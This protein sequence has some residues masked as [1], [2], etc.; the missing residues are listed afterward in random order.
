MNAILHRRKHKEE[1]RR[2]ILDAAREI[3]VR[4]GY[5]S[6][7]MRKLAKKIEYSPG[8]VYLHFKSKE[9]LFECLVEESFERLLKTLIGLGNGHERQ[10][11]VDEL[12]KGLWAYVNFGLHNPNDYRFA[13]MLR[14]PMKK[15]PYQVHRAFEALRNMVRRCVE[16]K[17]FRAV[18][19][20]TTSQALW[21][22]AH[23]ITSL[24]IQRPAFPWVGKK[25]LITQMISCAVDSLVA[26]PGAPSEAGDHHANISSL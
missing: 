21:A 15:R 13:F 22:S 9:D 25:E 18:E 12:R 17:R 4:D 10:D 26:A 20:E 16:K 5:E 14:P 6:F 11:P 8:S 2:I 3:F 23:G 1:L 7:S 19:V 24:L